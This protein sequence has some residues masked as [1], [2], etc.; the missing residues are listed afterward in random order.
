MLEAQISTTGEVTVEGQHVG[1]IH[2]FQFMP[3]PQADTVE[4]NT[5]RN[6]AEKALAGEIEA[7]ADRFSAA[8]DS[9]LVIS[10]DGTIRWTGEPVAKL[11][12]GDKLFEPQIRLLA[13]DQLAGTAR[14]KIEGRLKAW[15][16]A[17]I[18]R[19]LGPAIQL[20]E[21]TELT[22]I[23]RGIAFQICESLGVLDRSK[24]L[25]EVRGLA[26]DVRGILRKLGVRFGAY[27]LYL[28][29]LLKPAPRTLAAQLWALRNGGLEQKG[30]DDIALLASSGRTSI[31]LDTEISAGLYLAAGFRI[32]GVRAVRIDILERLADLIRPAISYRPGVTPGEPPAGTA[33]ENGFVAT[34]AMTSLVGCAGEDFVSILRY[35]GYVS[36]TRQGPA[37]TAKL[38]PAAPLQGI[39]VKPAEAEQTETAAV[40]ETG[41]EI[42]EAETQ[43]SGQEPAAQ[44]DVSVVGE[45]IPSSMEPVAAEA[46]AD[47]A[48]PV[49]QAGEEDGLI[50]SSDAAE[51]TEQPETEADSVAEVPPEPEMVEIWRQKRHHH[52]EGGHAKHGHGRHRQ[53]Q[54]HGAAQNDRARPD[55]PGTEHQDQ[56]S[57]RRPDGDNN[58]PRS[59][60]PDRRGERP[61]YQ[62]KRS[63]K[64]GSR[65]QQKGQ[66][67]RKREERREK[68]HDPDSPFA[69][70]LALKS[71]LENGKS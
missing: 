69:K 40:S 50:S 45:T 48:A 14:E 10:N 22:G 64:H 19:L 58:S 28:P 12:P 31:P 27:H 29:A 56:R 62:G 5:L 44:A 42:V 41:S 23:A 55:Q 20:E 46:A 6:A 4:V 1:H 7:R 47:A 21:A 66:F 68:Q 53:H 39:I 13:D 30:I 9:S 49:E 61:G 32:C 3:D 43:T 70:L 25:Q 35:L 37:I 18:V 60:R 51:K 67:E 71:Q 8:A 65:D 2:G 26:Q 59:P 17:Y 57:N 11:E 15:L 34:V 38:I 16:K 52:H 54:R 33:D 63:D 36:E 24:V